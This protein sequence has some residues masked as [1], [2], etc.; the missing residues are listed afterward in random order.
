MR[1]AGTPGLADA[2]SAVGGH[3]ASTGRSVRIAPARGLTLP[4]VVELWNYRHILSVLVWRNVTR[5]YRQTLL[6]PLWF[7]IKPFVRMV[8]FSLVL[9]KMAGLPS[10]GVPYP[11]FIYAALLPWEMF[12][13]GITRATGCFVT[14]DHII[15]KIYFPRLL[16]P[17]SEV[18]SALF[19]YFLS[20]VILVAMM[21]F[22]GFPFTW[23]LLALPLLLGVVMAFALSLGL[24]LA[25][26]NARFRDVSELL[27][28]GIRIW[29]YAT[30]VVYSASVVTERIP[31]RL[32]TLYGLNPMVGLSEAFR[33]AVLGIGPAPDLRLVLTGVGILLL[34][35][36]SCVVFLRSEHSIVDVV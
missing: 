30:P 12:T 1:G 14:Y 18:V 17:A 16:A 8:L 36:V 9:G 22:Y 15:S 10:E 35:L 32:H 4:D 2:D 26:W 25:A 31:E 6:G 7:V 27:S 13:S 28:H 19:D 34:L 23:R 29:F 11:I 3:G 20:F 24:L 21:L 5:R 33:W